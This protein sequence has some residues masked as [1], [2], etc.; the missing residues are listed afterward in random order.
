MLLP[1][2]ATFFLDSL[3]LSNMRVHNLEARSSGVVI[4]AK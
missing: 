4:V 2:L 1:A 3:S